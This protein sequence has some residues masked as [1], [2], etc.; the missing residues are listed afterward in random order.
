MVR[1]AR[2]TATAKVDGTGRYTELP[3][4]STV[5]VGFRVAQRAGEWRIAARVCAF[6]WT[7]TVPFDPARGFRF[8]TGWTLG[9]RD[10]TDITY[11]DFSFTLQED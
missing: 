10:R 1:T 6:D 7:V 8:E 11:S 5:Q 4:D 2:A 9:A 3:A